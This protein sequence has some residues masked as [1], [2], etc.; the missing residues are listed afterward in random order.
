MRITP[1][2]RWVYSNLFRNHFHAMKLHQ[3]AQCLGFCISVYLLVH[4]CAYVHAFVYLEIDQSEV[5]QSS[6]I[7]LLKETTWLQKITHPI[8]VWKK[9]KNDDRVFANT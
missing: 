5:S 4:I 2:R 3:K 7:I 1:A 9:Q 6:H 8:I